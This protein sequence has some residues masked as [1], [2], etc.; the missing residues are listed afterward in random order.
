M[1][2]MAMVVAWGVL[3]PESFLQSSWFGILAAFVALNTVMY[4]ALAVAKTLPKT[5]VSDWVLRRNTRS[6]TR[7]IYP[8]GPD[9]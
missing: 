5:Y 2:A 1:T 7:S 9:A 3:I 4:L 8:D 6:Q